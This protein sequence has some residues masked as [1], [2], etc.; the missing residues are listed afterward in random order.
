MDIYLHTLGNLI[1]YNTLLKHQIK[2]EE[3]NL[4]VERITNLEHL[5]DSIIFK[6]QVLQII[7]NKNYDEDFIHIINRLCQLS[8]SNSDLVALNS[9]ILKQ[10]YKKYPITKE[11]E[12]FSFGIFEFIHN[13]IFEARD[14]YERP[15]TYKGFEDIQTNIPEYWFKDNPYILWN[16][17]YLLNNIVNA[18][19]RQKLIDIDNQKDFMSKEN[20]GEYLQK[21]KANLIEQITSLSQDF[22]DRNFIFSYLRN[23][24]K[25]EKEYLTGYVLS[26]ILSSLNP[27]EYSKYIELDYTKYPTNHDWQFEK[28]SL[29]DYSELIVLSNFDRLVNL[30]TNILLVKE[31]ETDNKKGNETIEE[32]IEEEFIKIETG[33][34]SLKEEVIASIQENSVNIPTEYILSIPILDLIYKEFNDELWND[35]TLVEF[36]DMFTTNIHK[37]EN[38]TLKPKQT[39]RFYYLLKKIWINS[40]NKSLFNTEKEWIIPFLQNYQLSYSAY[41]NQFIRNEGGM[42]HR[43]FMKSVDKILPKDE[44]N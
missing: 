24:N 35:I 2:A 40:G 12:Q 11:L 5:P 38:F 39:V 43:N 31:L 41:T 7:N 10:L 20:I 13:D 23:N 6:T 32:C 37:Q 21:Q 18:Q 36:L 42:K 30:L 44:I 34:L 3:E 25:N 26:D 9:P 14:E 22:C 28:K 19:V 15:I 4:L 8:Q 27:S 16:T 1:T 17:Y 29:K 33:D